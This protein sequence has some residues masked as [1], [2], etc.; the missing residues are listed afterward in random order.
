MYVAYFDEV[1]PD[2]KAGRLSY[3]LGAVVIRAADVAEIE[4]LMTELSKEVF[5]STELNAKTEFHAAHIYAGKGNFKGVEV[6]ARLEVLARIAKIL[7]N[8]DKIKLAY[9]CINIEKLFPGTDAAEQA[10][11]HLLE[12]VQKCVGKDVA[13]LIG[14]LDDEQAKNMVADFARYR[15]QGTNSRYGTVISRIVDS[16]HFCRSHHSR[17]IQLADAHAFLRSQLNLRSTS[18]NSQFLFEAIKD[19]DLWPT[20]FKD[21]P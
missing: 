14:D 1:K 17:M 13:I 10:F 12:R 9:A 20:S 6:G 16:V 5:G 3:L 7:S 4:S 11:M 19:A 18:K 2:A 15:T 21:W 8:R